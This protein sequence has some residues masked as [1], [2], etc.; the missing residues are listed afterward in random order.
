MDCLHL[1]R[2]DFFISKAW[3]Q[4]HSRGTRGNPVGNQETNQRLVIKF[5]F[6]DI[7]YSVKIKENRILTLP[8]A[9]KLI[10]IFKQ[11]NFLSSNE[12]SSLVCIICESENQSAFNL[13]FD[14]SLQLNFANVWPA[15][16]PRSYTIGRFPSSY[17]C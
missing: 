7:F 4:W 17:N 1:S 6:D 10:V 16:F 5:R 9:K 11:S 8:K 13:N 3:M 12:S 15:C 2:K 14:R